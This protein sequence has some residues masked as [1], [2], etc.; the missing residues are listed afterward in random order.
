MCKKLQTLRQDFP[1]SVCCD[2]LTHGQHAFAV[3]L[4]QNSQVNLDRVLLNRCHKH[5]RG[6]TLLHAAAGLYGIVVVDFPG[7]KNS[8]PLPFLLRSCS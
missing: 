1:D 8:S 3:L 4:A 7:R 5:A 6:K 2:M